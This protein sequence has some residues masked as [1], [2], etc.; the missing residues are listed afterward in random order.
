MIKKIAVLLAFLSFGLIFYTPVKAETIY[1]FLDGKFYDSSAN[2][3]Y[4]CFLDGN[5]YDMN[6]K[7]AFVNP[8][9][10]VSFNVVPATAQAVT[11]APVAQVIAPVLPTTCNLSL[12]GS[13]IT[14]ISSSKIYDVKIS[15]NKEASYKLFIYQGNASL[16]SLTVQGIN[17]SFSPFVGNLRYNETGFYDSASMSFIIPISGQTNEYMIALYGSGGQ[18]SLTDIK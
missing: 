8:Q 4:M 15:C 6:Q 16:T 17:G 9:I 5:C 2:L 14:M 13:T 11:P 7:F 3:K 1:G 18:I 12:N 10:K